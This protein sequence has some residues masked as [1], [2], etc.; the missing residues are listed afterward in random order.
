MKKREPLKNYTK[1]PQVRRGMTPEARE[2]RLISLAYDLVEQRLI[3]GTATSQ[4]TTHF[5]KLGS[6]KEKIEKEILEKQKDLITAKTEAYQSQ[7]RVEELY[8]EAIKAFRSYNGAG[9]ED[10]NL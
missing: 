7:K 1:S 2:N 3:D 6:T 5:L 8:S 4:E 9:Q 10:E